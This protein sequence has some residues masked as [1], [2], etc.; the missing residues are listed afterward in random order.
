MDTNQNIDCEFSTLETFDSKDDDKLSS[1]VSSVVIESDSES[2]KITRKNQNS[3]VYPKNHCNFGNIS[4]TNSSNVQFGHTYH[5]HGNVV[6]NRRINK[7]NN[8]EEEFPDNKN[9][10]TS[11]ASNLKRIQK[12]ILNSSLQFQMRTP[13]QIFE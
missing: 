4:I 13:V 6:V 12:E 11:T 5:Y 3:R 10:P 8:R 1:V 7:N 9:E 2:F